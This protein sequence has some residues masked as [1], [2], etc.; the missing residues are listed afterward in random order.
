MPVVQSTRDNRVSTKT[1]CSIDLTTILEA[2]RFH[3]D[4]DVK[5]EATEIVNAA[6][7]LQQQ[8]IALVER[9]KVE[10]IADLENKWADA[11]MLKSQLEDELKTANLR[12]YEFQA[13]AGRIGGRARQASIRLQ[14]H[15]ALKKTWVEALLS[16]KD[17]IAWESKL[18]ELQAAVEASRK[19]SAELQTLVNCHNEDLSVLANKVRS[20][21]AEAISLYSK[22]QR[23]KG[24]AD[25]IPDRATGLHS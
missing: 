20:A 2:R 25:S 13:E 12:T 6:Y 14:E 3:S 22:I 18:A 10:T 9:L 15:L 5:A 8:A 21:T 24:S 19:E 17:R 23:L 1:V 7:T 16:P 4:P 11:L